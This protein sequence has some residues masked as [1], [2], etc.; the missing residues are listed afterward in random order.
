[1]KFYIPV[2][3]T[4]VAIATLAGV[5]HINANNHT[6]ADGHT[7][8]CGVGFFYDMDHLELV[9][10]HAMEELT[11]NCGLTLLDERDERNIE[12]TPIIDEPFRTFYGAPAGHIISKHSVITGKPGEEIL[13]VNWELSPEMHRQMVLV[14]LEKMDR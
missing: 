14:A 1:M 4:L 12:Y 5:V 11:D 13:T 3:C 8:I 9:D 2:I 7:M 10:F 6:T